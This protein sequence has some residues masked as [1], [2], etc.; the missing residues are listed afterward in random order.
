MLRPADLRHSAK[1]DG[2]VSGFPLTIEIVRTGSGQ[3]KHTWTR[4]WLGYEALNLGLEITE[5]GV[6]SAIARHFGR[7]D[8]EVGDAAFDARLKVR[9]SDPAA[10]R[11]Y[12]DA[13]RRHFI[14]RF[15][16]AHRGTVIDDHGITWSK[17]GRVTDVT[18]LLATIETMVS[19]GRALA[20]LTAVDSGLVPDAE[21][22]PQASAPAAESV[23]EAPAESEPEPEPEPEPELPGHSV[24]VSEFCRSVFAPGALSYAAA[25]TFREQFEGQAVSWAGTLESASPYHFDFV[26]GPGHGV[27]AAVT[28]H[29][30]DGSLLGGSK[31]RAMLQLPADTAD[32]AARIGRGIAFS[33]SLA[34]V[35]G[36]RHEV[37]VRDARL[38]A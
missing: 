38:S 20:P 21:F 32:L 25:Q 23:L 2:D 27:R 26:F 15:F 22:R 19:V 12:L 17:R 5:E 31:V 36:F 6:M 37:F 28:I 30:L 11:D 34:K 14:E 35:D 8:I 3:Y 24:S 33:G 16:A 13:N 18:E 7:G 1:L 4:Y 10:V 29:E 9:G